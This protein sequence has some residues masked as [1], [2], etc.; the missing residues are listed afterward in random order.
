MSDA[1]PVLLGDGEQGRVRTRRLHGCLG[2]AVGLALAVLTATLL[3]R[4]WNACDVGVN[5][6]ANGGFL[7]FLFVPGLWAL[8]TL[9]W[10]AVGLVLGN[11]PPLVRALTLAVTL[12]A[13]VWC[14]VSVFW[15]GS[16][17]T[18]ACPDGVPLWWPGFVPAP[19]F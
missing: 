10:A 1:D 7:L 14:V 19:G 2:T 12:C 16:A 18:A 3:G 9:A 5:N 13:L 17:A 8:L 15:D 6:A 4:S 11:R